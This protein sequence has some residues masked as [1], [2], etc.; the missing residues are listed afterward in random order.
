MKSRFFGL[1]VRLCVLPRDINVPKGPGPI[2]LFR[3][4]EFSGFIRRVRRPT[5][6]SCSHPSGSGPRSRR[7]ATAGP[8]PIPTASGPEQRQYR[9]RFSRA[10][11]EAGMGVTPTHLIP[12]KKYHLGPL[13]PHFR[14]RKRGS[15][16]CFRGFF[17][18]I[19]ISHCLPTHPSLW[20]R[21]PSASPRGHAVII[22]VQGRKRKEEFWKQRI[23]PITR[24]LVSSVTF[25]VQE[26]VSADHV[27]ASR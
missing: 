12:L 21:V 4:C 6:L 8:G 25:A 5:T 24:I 22:G 3:S 15:F 1:R 20:F 27:I 13:Y 2:V 17:S 14:P 18:G 11:I 16:G 7:H 19:H 23:A 10:G 26:E 9:T